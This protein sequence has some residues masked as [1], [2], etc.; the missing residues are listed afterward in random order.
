MKFYSLNEIF[1][2]YE[3]SKIKLELSFVHKGGFLGAEKKETYE[4][5]T[6]IMVDG[7]FAYS[8]V[9]AKE[10]PFRLSPRPRSLVSVSG[11]IDSPKLKEPIIVKEVAFM[12]DP[13]ILI[14]PL[15]I[16]PSDLRKTTSIEF[17]QAPQNPHLFSEAVVIDSK[18][19]RF[20]QTDFV[21]DEKD[22]RYI[23][24]SHSQF[25]FLTGAFDPGKGD[26]VFSQKGELLGIMVNNDYAF[27]VK[28][29]GARIHAGSRTVLGDAFA[30]PKTNVLLSSLGKKL[31]GLNKKFR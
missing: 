7:S 26:L 24:V 20:G 21:R 4:M 22:S 23:K 13:R 8:L 19:G 10:S 31:F 18:Q 6:I 30:P 9:H 15:Y 28:N 1:T 16:N 5:D 17:F 29:L 14:I 27:H 25:A 2:R 3:E 12:D 11:V